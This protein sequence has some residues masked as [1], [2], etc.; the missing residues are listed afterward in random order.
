MLL[1]VINSVGTSGVL[2]HGRYTCI[3]AY[4]QTD[5]GKCYNNMKCTYLQVKRMANN[6]DHQKRNT[7][8]TLIHI[9][10][11]AMIFKF[12]ITLKGS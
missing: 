11:I 9:P 4:R 1:T 6:S 2:K 8:H 7:K 3:G 5:A 12:Q 10:S